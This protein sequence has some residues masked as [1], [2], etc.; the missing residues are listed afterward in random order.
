MDDGV[1]S[2]RLRRWSL[3]RG[4][5]DPDMTITEAFRLPDRRPR[6]RLVDRVSRGAEGGVAVGRHGQHGDA[7]LAEWHLACAMD[8]GQPFD[9]EPVRDLA[10]DRREDAERHRLV[11]L[12]AEGLDR[13]SRMTSGLG[14][15]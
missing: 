7:R 6:L 14:F 8:D 4:L 10:G 13:P 3:A 12:V 15:L 11:R 9:A 5:A 1:P 2:P